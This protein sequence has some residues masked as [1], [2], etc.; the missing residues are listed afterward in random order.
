MCKCE[1]FINAQI[2]RSRQRWC[3]CSFINKSGKTKEQTLIHDI[4]TFKD[5]ISFENYIEPYDTLEEDWCTKS[6]TSPKVGLSRY[7]IL[8]DDIL[9]LK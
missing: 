8:H 6:N 2:T 9:S 1:Y 3:S 7:D 5:L 4:T